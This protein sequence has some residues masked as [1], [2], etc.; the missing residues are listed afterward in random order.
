MSESLCCSSSFKGHLNIQ[1][2]DSLLLNKQILAQ[3]TSDFVQL[4]ND[5]R[6]GNVWFFSLSLKKIL[7]RRM[8]TLDYILYM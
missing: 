2:Q 4:A 1:G 3:K 5:R 8:H 6:H 7:P